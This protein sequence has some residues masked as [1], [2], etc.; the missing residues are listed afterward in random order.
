MYA[1]LHETILSPLALK[2]RAQTV[3]VCPLTNN[4]VINKRIKLKLTITLV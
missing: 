4:N 2:E 1:Y 3:E